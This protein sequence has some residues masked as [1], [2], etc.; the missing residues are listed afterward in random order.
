MRLLYISD[1]DDNDGMCFYAFD[2]T[3]PFALDPKSNSQS[4]F[5]WICLKFR[6]NLQGA[7]QRSDQRNHSNALHRHWDQP[8]PFSMWLRPSP[9]QLASAPPCYSLISHLLCKTA[10]RHGTSSAAL[11]KHEHAAHAAVDRRVNFEAC[12]SNVSGFFSQSF[13]YVHDHVR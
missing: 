7:K 9:T 5:R 3:Q 11:G 4:W 13:I 1:D 8:R 12:N 6:G 10:T 2:S